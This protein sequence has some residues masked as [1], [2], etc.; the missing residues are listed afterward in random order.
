[1]KKRLLFV[2]D[3]PLMLDSL[4]RAM[5]CQRLVWECVYLTD[6]HEAWNKVLEGGFDVV[7]ADVKMRGMSGLDLLD[8][9]RSTPHVSDIPV[10]ILTGSTD[11]ELKRQAL[12]LGAADLLDKPIEAEDLL[13][14]LRNLMRLKSYQ[15]QLKTSNRRLEQAVLE[16][17]EEL[18][19]SRLDIIWRLGKA[20][21]HRDQETGNHVIRVGCISRV[22]AEAM[23]LDRRRVEIL[24]L[25]APLHDI[26]KI[27]IPDAILMKRGPLSREEWVVMKQ[28]C[29]IGAR[30]LSEDSHIRSTF[31][32][33]RGAER[34][35]AARLVDNPFLE[36]AASIAATHHEKWDGSGYPRGLSGE[37][38]PLESRI[39]AIA[40][41]FDALTSLRP[42]KEPSTE[43]EAMQIIADAAAVHFDPAVHSVFRRTLPEIQSIREQFPDDDEPAF[44][45][46]ERT[47]EEMELVCR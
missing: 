39:V 22:I 25:A 14:R 44:W 24:F 42:Y 38:I 10:L 21:E 20:A 5:H 17:T 40:D 2:D 30:I 43:Y 27:G 12:D 26:G 18:F 4:R 6:P 9:I 36:M 32:Q 33:W 31:F 46:Q 35:P 41:V 19:H 15:D 11:R 16:R 7:V 34:R 37:S 29:R 1:L 45:E 3:E 13:A 8:R 28:H 47:R 23:G